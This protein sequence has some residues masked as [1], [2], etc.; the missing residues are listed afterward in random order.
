MVHVSNYMGPTFASIKLDPVTGEFANFENGGEITVQVN[1]L[2]FIMKFLMK[3][4][5]VF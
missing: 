4:V 5:F 2:T 3:T 1:F